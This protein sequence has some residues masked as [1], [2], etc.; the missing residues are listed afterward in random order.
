M[1]WRNLRIG[2]KLAIGFGC[3][4]VLI[5]IGGA[6]GYSGLKNIGRSLVIVGD[7]E[8]PLVDA[9]MEMK[10]SLM[11]AVTAMDGYRAATA[12]LSTSDASALQELEAD[13]LQAVEA[14]DKAAE[15][16]LSGGVLDGGQKVIKTDN[17]QLAELVR[18]ADRLHNDK[19]QRA[20][21]EMMA[22]GRTMLQQW[23]DSSAA[24]NGMEKVYD[25]VT[26][27]VGAIE[28]IVRQEIRQAASNAG[29]GAAAQRILDEEVPL[30]D[31]VNEIKFSLAMS[32]IALEEY[33]QTQDQDQLVAV[34]REYQ[35]QIEAFDTSVSAIL[36]GGTVD[37]VR[38]IATDNRLIRTA[39]QELDEDHAEFQAAAKMLMA[40][41]QAS[42][43]EAKQ[44]DEQMSSL[45][46]AAAEAIALLS[47]VEA[48][49]GDEM[50]AAKQSGEAS[51]ASAIFWQ[52]VVVCCSIVIGGL[53]GFIITRSLSKPISQGVAL[54][55]EIARGDFSQRLNLQRG[56]EVG[57]L[58]KALDGMAE[59]LQLKAELAETIADGNLDVSVVLASEKD[60]LGLALQ[61]MTD[62][63]NEI[64]GQVQVAG[65]Q[66][67]SGGGQVSDAA[68][69]LSQG[70]TESAA[71]LEEITSSM[72]EMSSRTRHN[73]ESASQANQLSN[74]AKLAAEKGNQQMQ[75]MVSAMM[76]INEAG[77]S[78]SKIIK[79]IDEIAFQ[80][81]LLALNAAVEAARAGQHGKGFAV[82]AEEVRN[83]AARSAKAAEETAQLI[84][85]SVQ[86]T[87]NG[88]HIASQTA[89][90][91]Q[92]IVSG[93]GQV[94]DLLE[95]ISAASN[96]Q[97]QGIA[98]V[99]QGL[100]QIDKV[101]QQN[102][103]NA[104]ESAA[105]AE[106]LSGQAEQM[107]Q[108]LQRFR[109]RGATQMTFVPP[110]A[111][112]PNRIA[113]QEMI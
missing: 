29:I 96:E 97:A 95:E 41:Y 9:S 2:V 26:D 7:E 78:I 110:P 45:D 73:A 19:Y 86:K 43:A 102:T 63:L 113:W 109:L 112:S 57:K 12:T 87:A 104:E 3:M 15:A 93:V 5:L 84:E 11:E 111:V 77:Q 42:L 64:L 1:S 14:F 108:M 85:G 47:Q 13:Y 21:Q 65:E 60:Q 28:L 91:L 4:L 90:A 34:E 100:T 8:A 10:I 88:S 22:S 35:Q 17:V 49:A 6:V 30:A 27:D 51:S 54:A 23:T 40:A 107:R 62:S 82:V 38:V 80:T 61:K 72:N 94:S 37:G 99:D 75:S 105:A 31:M 71:S 67:A 39:I 36:N 76:E 83:L 70:A 101:T 52:L 44:A 66:I 53:L 69:S 32:R 20:S 98:Q 59:N 48:L 92:E 81:N 74:D 46:A 103:A 16:I 89:T 25:E 50:A 24:M 106:E 55:D 79:T 33:I 58:A 56:D 68:Q 18:Q